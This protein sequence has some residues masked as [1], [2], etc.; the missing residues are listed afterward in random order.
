MDFLGGHNETIHRIIKATVCANNACEFLSGNT[1]WGLW[2]ALHACRVLWL[3]GTASSTLE[4]PE[5]EVK[6]SFVSSKLKFSVCFS[7][8]TL[9]ARQITGDTCSC[10]AHGILFYRQPLRQLWSKKY[11]KW[12]C[13]GLFLWFLSAMKQE[14]GTSFK[15]VALVF[16]IM[17][18]CSS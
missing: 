7:C 8:Q 13:R 2:G 16:A 15:M 3:L 18:S 14:R 12:G 9:S 11:H 4:S 6:H 5:T 1:D 10:C 17:I